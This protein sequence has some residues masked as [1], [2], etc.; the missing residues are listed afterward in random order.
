MSNGGGVYFCGNGGS[1]ADSQHLAT[2]LV[3]RFKKNRIPLKSVALTT[4]SSIITAISNDFSLMKY[5]PDR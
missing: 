5:L 2:E 3:G 4:D 1:A